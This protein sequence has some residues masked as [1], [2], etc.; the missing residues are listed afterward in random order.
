MNM[1]KLCVV[2]AVLCMKLTSTQN[3][4]NFA[5]FFFEHLCAVQ[6]RATFKLNSGKNL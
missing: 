1:L 6:T 2:A 4:L 3:N 5:L